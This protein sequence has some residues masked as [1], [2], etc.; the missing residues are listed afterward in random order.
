[1]GLGKVRISSP[2]TGE[3]FGTVC[4]I[5]HSADYPNDCFYCT[6]SRAS[7][8]AFPRRVSPQRFT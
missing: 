6:S 1:M 4:L 8:G 2:S 3:C 7:G 5:V